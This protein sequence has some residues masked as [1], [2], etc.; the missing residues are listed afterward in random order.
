MIDVGHFDSSQVPSHS[1]AEECHLKS[2]QDELEQDETRITVDS[3]KVLPSE[4]ENVVG[5]RD[6]AV[7]VGGASAGVSRGSNPRYCR[8]R[9]AW[10]SED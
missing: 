7:W 4:S 5:M 3:N 1:Q 9:G 6:V 2:G 8:R 10:Q